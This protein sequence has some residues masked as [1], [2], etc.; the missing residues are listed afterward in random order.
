MDPL[1]QVLIELTVKSF[2][3]QDSSQ[4]WINRSNAS[5]MTQESLDYLYWNQ[6]WNYFKQGSEKSCDLI[7][8]LGI[9]LQGLLFVIS[10]STL[11]CKYTHP[12]S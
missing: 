11:L 3:F 7:D 10:F 8:S 12:M 9:V 4:N 6:I 1:R 5:N 2:V